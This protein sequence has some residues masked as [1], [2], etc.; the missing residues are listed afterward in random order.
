MECLQ[1]NADAYL[2]FYRRRTS[3][4]LG[5]KTQERIVEYKEK[6]EHRKNIAE[7]SSPISAQE[8][9][10][11]LDISLDNGLPTPP[12]DS[13]FGRPTGKL[14]ELLDLTWSKQLGASV[15]SLT[16]SDDPPDFEDAH[17]D[18]IIMEVIDGFDSSS[19]T[20]FGVYLGG[21]SSNRNSPTS[22]LDAEVDFA[23]PAQM[24]WNDELYS[25]LRSKEMDKLS[26]AGS[27]N[28][29]ESG[30]NF[31]SPSYSNASSENTNETGQKTFT[32]ADEDLGAERT[33]SP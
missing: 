5:G 31:A 20:N 26:P 7:A 14:A 27:D 8:G 25:G 18:P 2:L 1:Q 28:W 16:P 6:A 19:D 4:P 21:S 17:S 10:I 33:H 9:P 12:D 23:N 15:S 3:R 32:T 13:K 30:S 24:K 11:S 29:A 22:S